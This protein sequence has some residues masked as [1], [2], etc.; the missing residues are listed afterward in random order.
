MDTPSTPRRPGPAMLVVRLLLG[1]LFVLAASLKL[2]HPQD[3]ANSVLAFKVFPPAAD[4]LNYLVTFVVPWTEM[5]CGVLLIVGLWARSA[6]L[7]LAL[8]LG[9]FLGGIISVLWRKLDVS[10]GCFGKFEFPCGKAVG[11]CHIARNGVLLVM[12]L[13]VLVRGPGLGALDNACCRSTP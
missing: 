11:P 3:F 10:C 6:A 12:A 5:L 7:V 8:L 4:H 9:V 1:G 2:A 13:L